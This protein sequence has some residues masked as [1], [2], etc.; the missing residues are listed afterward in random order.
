MR[1]EVSGGSHPSEVVPHCCSPGHTQTPGPGI[2]AASTPGALAGL[3]PLSA[4]HPR[5]PTACLWPLHQCHPWLASLHPLPRCH[6]VS[7]RLAPRWHSGPL[8]APSQ[9]LVYKAGGRSRG[10][11]GGGLNLRMGTVHCQGLPVLRQAGGTGVPL[12][13]ARAAPAQ[14]AASPVEVELERPCSA[15][16][17]PAPRTGRKQTRSCPQDALARKDAGPGDSPELPRDEGRTASRG[18]LAD[19]PQGRNAQG[20][21]TREK[22]G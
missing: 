11:P 2:R 9:Q 10:R 21:V 20:P 7:A 5:L 18:Q 4:S 12:P 16:L 8:W 22:Q 3:S 1:N 15:R 6:L 13:R 14:W 17:M 19:C